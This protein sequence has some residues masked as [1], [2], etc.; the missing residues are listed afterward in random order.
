MIRDGAVAVC[1]LLTVVL[2][3]CNLRTPGTPR[4]LGDVEYASAFATGREVMG[5]HCS[6]ASADAE[7]GVIQSRP[8]LVKVRGERLLGGS[9]ARHVATL[10]IV[11]RGGEVVAYASVALQREGSSIHQTRPRNGENYDSVPNLTPARTQD[12]GRPL[13]G[14]ASSGEVGLFP[15][16]R[17]SPGALEAGSSSLRADMSAHPE[18][19]GIS[20]SPFPRTRRR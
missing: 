6:I 16:I 9:P 19:V 17:G 3:G 14:A 2:S 15:G 11:R 7:T 4:A 12:P 20:F 10:R 18:R 13:Q 1:V 8:R 5:Q